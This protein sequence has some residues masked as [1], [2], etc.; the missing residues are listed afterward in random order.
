MRWVQKALIVLKIKHG[1]P[2]EKKKKKRKTSL[3]ESLIFLPISPE[4][5]DMKL[6]VQV[7]NEPDIDRVETAHLFRNSFHI[8]S[9]G[10]TPHKSHREMN[11]KKNLG[12]LNGF[13]CMLFVMIIHM[14]VVGVALDAAL[15]RGPPKKIWTAKNSTFEPKKS[16]I[17][18]FYVAGGY[19]VSERGKKESNESPENPKIS[20]MLSF[21]IRMLARKSFPQC[22]SCSL[23]S[24][25]LSLVSYTI[26]TM[27]SRWESNMQQVVIFF[28]NM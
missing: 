17:A 19:V 8:K 24:P 1:D 11:M 2:R 3:I 22:S 4:R 5:L 20:E 9:H 7:S 28:S 6:I 27:W 10:N 23:F 25:F 21:C 16:E 12:N 18:L 13:C 15:W 26:S 14:I